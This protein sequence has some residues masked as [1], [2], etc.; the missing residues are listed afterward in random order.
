MSASDET[1]SVNCVEF[2]YGKIPVFTVSSVC[3]LRAKS[4]DKT[5]EALH[6]LNYRNMLILVYRVETEGKR[7]LKYNE[8]NNLSRRWDLLHLTTLVEA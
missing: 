7:A 6:W 4:G 3:W 5:Q 2:V 8:D 1:G